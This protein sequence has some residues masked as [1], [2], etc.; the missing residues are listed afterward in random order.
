MPLVRGSSLVTCVRLLVVS[1]EFRVPRVFRKS[2][3][4]DLSLN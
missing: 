3:L 2:K 1:G 4:I